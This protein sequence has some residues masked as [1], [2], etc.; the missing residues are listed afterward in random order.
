MGWKNRSEKRHT[1]RH[2]ATSTRG[3]GC[4]FG[5]CWL[6]TSLVFVAAS[7]AV[8]FCQGGERKAVVLNDTYDDENYYTS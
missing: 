5:C 8:G 6:W 1:D 2:T 3:L 4:G 7:G